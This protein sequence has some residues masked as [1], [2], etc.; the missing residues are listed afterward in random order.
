MWTR[1][2]LL[3]GWDPLAR[4]PT[5]SGPKRKQFDLTAAKLVVAGRYGDSGDDHC[6]HRK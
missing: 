3:F 1:D 6:P 2:K 5:V 4:F